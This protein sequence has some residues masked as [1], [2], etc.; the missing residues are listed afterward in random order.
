MFARGNVECDV[1]ERRA[2]A[3]HHGYICEFQQRGMLWVDGSFQ[4]E[5]RPLIQVRRLRFQLSLHI[6]SER[7]LQAR[8]Y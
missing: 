3:A 4:C 8:R 1:V 2:S 5:R 6:V 7:A